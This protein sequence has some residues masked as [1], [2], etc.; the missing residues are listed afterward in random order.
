MLCLLCLR[1]LLHLLYLLYSLYLLCLLHLGAG[2]DA[3]AALE[4]LWAWMDGSPFHIH[5]GE[6]VTPARMGTRLRELRASHAAD[7]RRELEDEILGELTRTRIAYTDYTEEDERLRLERKKADAEAEL[8]W[9]VDRSFQ[10]LN[11]G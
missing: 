8:V 7:A 11:E 9:K 5:G 10:G 4:D 6:L 3:D 1:C 2:A